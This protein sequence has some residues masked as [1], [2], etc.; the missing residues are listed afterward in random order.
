VEVSNPYDFA[1]PSGTL[2]GKVFHTLNADERTVPE[3]QSL[4]AAFNGSSYFELYRPVDDVRIPRLLPHQTIQ[5]PVYLYEYTGAKYPW[6][7]HT[8]TQNE[9]LHMYNFIEN[10]TFS[11]RV[12]F[13]LPPAAQ[14]AAEH[15][16]PA[17]EAGYVYAALS[18]GLNFTGSPAYAHAP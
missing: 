3:I 2:R 4:S 9:F 12:D 14:Y 7:P 10:F 5:V 6:S 16:V 8:V 11:F 17:N 18:R 15:A 1:T 13:D